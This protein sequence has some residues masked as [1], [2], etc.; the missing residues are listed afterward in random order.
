MPRIRTLKPEHRGHR[1]IA[2]LSDAAYRGWIGLINEVDDDGR[3]VYDPDCLNA[4]IFVIRRKTRRQFET[5][6]SELQAARLLRVYL[7]PD[8]LEPVLALHD[9]DDH[10]PRDK[11][12]YRPSTLPGDS[13][14][15]LLSL[16]GASQGSQPSLGTG[17][18]EG[19]REGREAANAGPSPPAPLS[20]QIP[21]SIRTALSKCPAF[22]SV[23]RLQTPGFWQTQ[24]RAHAGVDF[25]RELL[26]AQAWITANPSRAPKSNVPAFLHRWFRKAAEDQA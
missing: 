23:L 2:R 25:A 17:N 18:R 19:N 16:N 1:K 4:A 26:E 15:T 13:G 24:I 11:Y 9:F 3:V 8:H 22:A 5:L 6:M 10:Q 21:E 20:F 12:H 14:A 7:A